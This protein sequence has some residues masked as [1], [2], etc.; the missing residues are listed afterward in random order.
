MQTWDARIEAVA[1]PS[2]RKYSGKPNPYISTVYGIP[3]QH[4]HFIDP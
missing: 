4:P 3:L 1:G 2:S